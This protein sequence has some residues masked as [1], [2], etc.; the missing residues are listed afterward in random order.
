MA[1]HIPTMD[2]ILDFYN[3]RVVAQYLPEF[4]RGVLS[5]MGISL[6]ALVLSLIIGT[7]SALMSLSST[8]AL[9][10]I[11]GGYISLIRSTPLLIQIYLIYFVLPA[12]PFLD[13]R[14]T[15]LEGG[16]IA[17]GL[18]AGA[19]MSEIIRAG[20][21]SIE[22]GQIEGA[23]SVGMTYLQR[24]RYVILPQAIARVIPPLL[25]QTAVLIK[26]SSLV[27]FI[28]VFELFGAGLTVLNERL[29]PNE[30]FLTVAACYLGIYYLMSLF[31]SHAQRKLGGAYG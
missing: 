1:G 31:S 20:I 7:L 14:L 29:M 22:R 18:N 10:N 25:G 21:V 23:M 9:R 28:G 6:V 4:G 19:F 12:L 3:Y 16:I 2:W 11:A 27:S 13:R 15:E 17:L 30:A 26:D 8:A 5:T 24:M